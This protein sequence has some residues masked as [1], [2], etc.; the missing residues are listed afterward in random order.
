MENEIEKYRKRIFKSKEEYRKELA[1]LPFEK[2]IEILVKIQKR[3]KYLKK[4]KINKVSP[5][6]KNQKF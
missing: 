4:F 3:A 5:L 6:P 2:K 1:K